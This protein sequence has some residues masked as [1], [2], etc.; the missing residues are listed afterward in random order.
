MKQ[1]IL[2]TM[3]PIVI[4]Q[5][6]QGRERA[7]DIFS[8]LMKDRII[9]IG[10]PIDDSIANAV[11]AQLLFLSGED[12]EKAIDIFINSP[13]GSISAGMAIID[14]MNYVTAPI[15][16]NVVGMAA[17]MAAVIL[18]CGDKGKRFALPNSEVLIHQPSGGIGGQATDIDLY[19]RHILKTRE[20]LNNILVD[21]TGQAYDKI[22]KDVD[23]DYIMSAEEAVTYGIV[24][25]IVKKAPSRNDDDDE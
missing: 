14:T 11:V 3:T 25:K 16:T 13:G 2:N 10:T 17:S 20:K 9:F 24:D 1:S 5:D 12:D 23:R 15:R 4:E 22:A 19:A 21:R 7:Y 6:S 18:A 8:R